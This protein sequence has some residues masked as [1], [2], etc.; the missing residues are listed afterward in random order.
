MLGEPAP[1]DVVPR[2]FTAA[3]LVADDRPRLSAVD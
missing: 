1:I 2:P 3:E